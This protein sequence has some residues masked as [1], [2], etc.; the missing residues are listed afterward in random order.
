MNKTVRVTEG[1]E[2]CLTPLGLEQ[3]RVRA[4]F[5][6]SSEYRYAYLLSVPLSWVEKGY[7]KEANK[8]SNNG[9]KQS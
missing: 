5:E 2:W 8:E 7:V 1:K 6:L 4:K 3:P 9:E